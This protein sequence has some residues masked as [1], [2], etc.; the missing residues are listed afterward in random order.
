MPG[1]PETKEYVTSLRVCN[2]LSIALTFALEPWG[3]QYKL[4]PEETFEIVARGPEGD[5]LEVEF[6]DDQIILYGWPGSV[7][8]L[9]HIPE[10]RPDGYLPEGVLFATETEVEAAFGT[11]N[12][13]RQTLCGG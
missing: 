10:L 13:R 2:S 4:A 6:A 8:T 7:V 9:F 1:D 3:K 11:G 12:V 5:S